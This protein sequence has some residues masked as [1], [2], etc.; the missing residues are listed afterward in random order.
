[1]DNKIQYNNF[2]PTAEPMQIGGKEQY[3]KARNIS[4]STFTVQA[5]KKKNKPNMTAISTSLSPI[6]E[7][8]KAPQSDNLKKLVFFF[9]VQKTGYGFL[10]SDFLQQIR[11]L[12]ADPH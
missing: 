10:D 8:K 1:M 2:I 3:N 7:Y 11:K 6:V 9:L 12:E 4:I 5:S